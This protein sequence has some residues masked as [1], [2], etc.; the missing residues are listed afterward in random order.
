MADIA[1]RQTVEADFDAIVALNL[2]EVAHTSE[3]DRTRLA[4]LHGMAGYHK[5][6]TVD[7]VVAA[8]LLAMKHDCGYLNENFAWFSARFGTFLYIDRIVVDKGHRGLGLGSLLYEDVFGHAMALGIPTIACEYNVVPPNEPSRKFHE[9]F[10]FREAGRQWLGNDSKQVSLQVA[11][12]GQVD[13]PD[14]SRKRGP[15]D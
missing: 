15:T 5:V 13:R 6:A 2:A 10:G 7:G 12:A 1:I 3:M 8:F 11:E 9:R 14:V 4:A